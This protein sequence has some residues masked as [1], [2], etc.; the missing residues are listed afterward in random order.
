MTL[1]TNLCHTFWHLHAYH[2]LWTH[3]WWTRTEEAL[4]RTKLLSTF[5]S[6]RARLWWLNVEYVGVSSK[7]QGLG[8]GCGFPYAC[9]RWWGRSF[10]RLFYLCLSLCYVRVWPRSSLKAEGRFLNYPFAKGELKSCDL[11]NLRGCVFVCASPKKML[12]GKSSN[13]WC[14]RL[15]AI[16]P[17]IAF[18]L[19]MFPRAREA[20][21]KNENNKVSRR[22][23]DLIKSCYS[24]FCTCISRPTLCIHLHSPKHLMLSTLFFHEETWLPS[25][26]V[27]V[28]I[29]PTNIDSGTRSYPDCADCHLACRTHFYRRAVYLDEKLEGCLHANYSCWVRGKKVAVL[30]LL[31]VIPAAVPCLN[32]RERERGS[33][34]F[35]FEVRC[36]LFVY[37]DSSLEMFIWAIKPIETVHSRYEERDWW[38]NECGCGLCILHTDYV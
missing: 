25:I 31:Y 32:P 21:A 15:F 33:R 28:D 30:S 17:A 6:A 14:V 36:A 34:L 26:D 2:K 1:T 5:S 16:R 10:S 9:H 13:Y 18:L 20:T 37:K 27:I 8:L 12:H 35:C 19:F 24:F 23:Q 7:V 29:H 4:S 38:R 11:V 3:A 22:V